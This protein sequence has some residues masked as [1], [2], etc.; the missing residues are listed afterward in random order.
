MRA[1]ARIKFCGSIKLDIFRCQACLP[2]TIF[3]RASFQLCMHA[4]LP[5]KR[6]VTLQTAFDNN[7]LSPK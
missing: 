7:R 5:K 4:E 6:K 2:E 3:P 1:S